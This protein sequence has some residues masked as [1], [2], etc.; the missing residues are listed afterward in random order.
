M[1]NFEDVTDAVRHFI[2]KGVIIRTVINDMT[3]DGSTADPGQQAVRDA[4][5]AFLAAK[6]LHIL[7]HNTKYTVEY[8]HFTPD[9]YIGLGL[10]VVGLRLRHPPFSFN[11]VGTHSTPYGAVL[12]GLSAFIVVF[13][14]SSIRLISIHWVV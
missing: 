11:C 12:V 1:R 3:S 13:R 5:I 6:L 7:L 9:T 2:R 10:W 4:M 14:F 8:F